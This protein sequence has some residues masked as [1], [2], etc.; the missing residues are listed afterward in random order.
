MDAL[1]PRL[2]VRDFETAAAFWTA[3]L[4]E[5][6]GVEPV[7][8]IPQAGYAHWDL[9]GESLLVLFSRAELARA[10]GTDTLPESAAAPTRDGG[11]LVLRVDDP[12]KAARTLLGHG[13]TLVAPAQDRPEWGPNL[14]TAHVRDPDGN[15]IELQSY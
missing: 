1:L 2:L 6:L 15:L 11:M 13:A 9:R 7:K 12:E 8:V 3:A 4:R 10:I 14:R 5:L